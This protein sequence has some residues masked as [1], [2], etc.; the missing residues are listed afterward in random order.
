MGYGPSEEELMRQTI[1]DELDRAFN[2]MLKQPPLTSENVADVLSR[3][4]GYKVAQHADGTLVADYTLPVGMY[5]TYPDGG[6]PHKAECQHTFVT[7]NSGWTS[8][9]YCR[10][11][12][13][14]KSDL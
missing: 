4:L 11:C 6:N 12:D 13:K 3:Q 7:Y 5:G 1:K 8:Y 9:E 10:F 14:K 2:E